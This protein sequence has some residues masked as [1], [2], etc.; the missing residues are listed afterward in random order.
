MLCITVYGIFC[1]HWQLTVFERLANDA[2]RHE[3]SLVVMYIHSVRCNEQTGLYTCIHHYTSNCSETPLLQSARSSVP[4]LG[5]I[6][7]LLDVIESCD[8]AHLLNLYAHTASPVTYSY[9]LGSWKS[10]S[11][12][13]RSHFSMKTQLQ[14]N[15]KPYPIPSR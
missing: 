10:I 12:I 13:W 14:L 15:I 8:G 5:V 1:L 2:C 3:H 4:L 9:F 6:V 11:S 7:P